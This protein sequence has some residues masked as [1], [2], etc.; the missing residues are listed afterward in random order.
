MDGRVQGSE[1]GLRVEQGAKEDA[2]R[3]SRKSTVTRMDQHQRV[4]PGERQ[5]EQSHNNRQGPRLYRTVPE[6][7]RKSAM[8]VVRIP[9]TL[10]FCVQSACTTS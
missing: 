8:P 2:G 5:T 9:E 1:N 7:L 6:S 10:F 4:E 3:G